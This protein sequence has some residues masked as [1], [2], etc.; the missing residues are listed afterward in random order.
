MRNVISLELHPSYIL[1]EKYLYGP[2]FHRLKNNN[3]SV[4]KSVKGITKIGSICATIYI[5]I[6]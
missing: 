4:K 6:T 2:L 1:F 5:E 3:K